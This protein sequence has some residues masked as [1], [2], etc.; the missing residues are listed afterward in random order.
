MSKETTNSSS[1]WY[2]HVA[3]DNNGHQ[4]AGNT[5]E[6]AQEALEQAQRD[7]VPSAEHKSITGTIINN[8]DSL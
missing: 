4:G 2:G 5:P 6:H 7:D 3:D 1:L 8:D